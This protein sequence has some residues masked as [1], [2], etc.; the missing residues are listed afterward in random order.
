MHQP[1]DADE[2]INPNR[3]GLFK[4]GTAEVL[5]IG[6]GRLT[7]ALCAGGGK[8]HH[9]QVGRNLLEVNR[10]AMIWSWVSVGMP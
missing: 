2:E 6:G 8:G 4:A 10:T 9:A 5:S 1:A 7:H 3:L